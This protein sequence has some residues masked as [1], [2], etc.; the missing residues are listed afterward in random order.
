MALNRDLRIR[1]SRIQHEIIKNNA[2]IE[3]KTLSDYARE[4][5]LASNHRTE[6]MIREIFEKV[7]KKNDRGTQNAFKSK[8][9]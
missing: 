2:E 1:V 5:I 7:V 6:K 8:N 9:D 4:K 3:G